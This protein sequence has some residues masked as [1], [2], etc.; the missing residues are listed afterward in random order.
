MK[1]VVADELPASALDLLRAEPGW[2]IN[3]QSGRTP[4][5]LAADLAD[6]DALMV[7]SATKVNAQLLEAAPQLRIVARAGTGVDNVD[8]TA[9]SARGI[10][11][12]NSPGAN[13]ISVAEHAVGLMLSL[14]RSVPAADQ[15]MKAG[16]WEKKKF[17]GTEVRGKT[18]GVVGLGR[19]GQEVAQRARGFGMRI[20]A[21]DPY[22]SADI[23]ASFGV[24][25]L[26]LDALCAQ[27]D[28]ITLHLPSTPETRHLFGDERFARCK[29]GAK[30]VN[31]ARGELIDEAALRRA[32]EQGI[33]AGA[34]LDVFEQEPPKDWS[35]AQLPQI[36][37]TP[38]I[39]ASTEEAQE[40][41]GTETAA[42]VRDFLRDGI[43]RNAVNFPAVHPDEMQRLQP[44]IR[45]ADR[46]GVLAAQLGVARIDALGVRY[47]GALTESPGVDVLAASAAAGLLRPILS[48]GVSIV[49]A[50][51]VARARGIDIAETRSSRG[52]HF[53]S[54]LS[55]KVHTDGGERWV[56][57]TVFAPNSLRLVSVRGVEVE[58]PLG[59]TLLIVANDDQPGVIGE[60][61]TILGRHRINIANF[62]LG[63]GADGAIGV[64]NVDEEA[65]MPQALD[66]AVAEIR[67]IRA[68]REVFVVRLGS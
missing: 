63:R 44:W 42:T 43:V 19:I 10:L 60:V 31:T 54:L 45:L 62:A 37:A 27:A 5:V 14:A 52:R 51:A 28:Y 24:E 23:A 59:G 67:Q 13:S 56:E 26:S 17:L 64:V 40:L 61:G 4:A 25:L 36:I 30:I 53:T 12:V 29:K 11:V 39:A 21:H 41:V 6:A 58:A 18:L 32:I 55:V 15:A 3:A 46:L 68:V 16:R 8:V 49:N 9:A 38:H 22:I 1:I 47:Y 20:V 7:R 57:G 65:G 66:A 34:G 50:R 33:I 2:I 35:L 48:S